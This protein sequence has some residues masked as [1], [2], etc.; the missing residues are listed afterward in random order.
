MRGVRFALFAGWVTMSLLAV[1]GFA[2]FTTPDGPQ[3]ESTTT[4]VTAA[5]DLGRGAG[6]LSALAFTYLVEAPLPDQA[7][8]SAAWEEAA[9]AT[10]STTVTT[11][12]IS[13]KPAAAATP[14]SSPTTT[15]TNRPPVVI[16]TE[17]EVRTLVAA[18]FHLEDIERA[19][20]VAYCESSFH[21]S[22]VNPRT[23]AS[24]LFQHMPRFWAERS[25]RAGW[26]GASIFDAQASTAVAAWLLY[27]D[28]VGWGHWDC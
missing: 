16:L 21:P 26:A 22:A 25:A 7:A 4:A 28:A 5:S 9:L 23:G 13:P 15:T 6:A 20:Q 3:Q 19:V 18:Y 2:A 24:G 27:S 8:E 1:A 11:V 14:R 10:R 17:A 12:T